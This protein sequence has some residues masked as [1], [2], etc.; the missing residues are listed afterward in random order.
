[1]EPHAAS[2]GS[3]G[4]RIEVLVATR[5]NVR[6]SDRARA[7]GIRVA[8]IAIM[9]LAAGAALLPAGKRISSD[10]IGGL[11]IASGLIEAVAGS[12]RREVRPFAMSA[13][14]GTALAGLLFLV[15]PA[16]DFFP[17]VPPVHARL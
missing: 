6:L 14:G 9:I 12:L 10:M 7:R 3:R 1:M 16:T 17:I 2:R 13:G 4:G 11:L 5:E 8:G 15:H